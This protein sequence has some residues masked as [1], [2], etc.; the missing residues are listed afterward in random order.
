MFDLQNA[1]YRTS[2]I[3]EENRLLTYKSQHLDY[4]FML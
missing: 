3:N 1:Y 2:F 4:V